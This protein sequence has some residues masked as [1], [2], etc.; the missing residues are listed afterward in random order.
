MASTRR[1]L[2]VRIRINYRCI[3]KIVIDPHYEKK[4]SGSV[5]D[6]I[7]VALVDQ[8]H[9]KIFFPV[10]RDAQGFDY[11]VNDR[12]EYSRK[13]YKLIWILHDEESYVGV[14][15]AYRR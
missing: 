3:N 6:E 1:V 7:I 9:E 15:N 8:L 14:I 10:I 11:F 12:M 5:T 13:F 4:H 2:P